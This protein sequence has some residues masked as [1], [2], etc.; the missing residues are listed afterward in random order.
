MARWHGGEELR[1]NVHIDVL[2]SSGRQTIRQLLPTIL[3]T[4]VYCAQHLSLPVAEQALKERKAAI[5]VSPISWMA[6]TFQL[7]SES[8]FTLLSGIAHDSV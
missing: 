3:C 5:S 6:E 2:S 8:R 7:N 1:S 4:P